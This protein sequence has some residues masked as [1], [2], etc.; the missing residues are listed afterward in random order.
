[1]IP[2]YGKLNLF[3]VTK[4]PYR[5]QNDRALEDLKQVESC[6]CKTEESIDSENNGNDQLHLQVII[7]SFVAVL[8]PFIHTHPTLEIFRKYF[9]Y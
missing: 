2:D 1:M 8:N 9:D 6:K 5:Y 7:I 4:N 3:S